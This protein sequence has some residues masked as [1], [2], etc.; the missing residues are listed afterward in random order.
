MSHTLGIGFTTP[1][2]SRGTGTMIPPAGGVPAVSLTSYVS[3][4]RAVRVLFV[5]CSLSVVI[6]VTAGGAAAAEF[7]PTSSHV[8][9]TVEQTTVTP[10]ETVGLDASNADASFVEFD[11]DG[12]DTYDRTDETDFVIKT[13]YSATGTY[14]PRVHADGDPDLVASCGTVTVQQNTPP[15]ANL[16]ITPNPA[17]TGETVIFDATGSTDTDGSIVEYRFRFNDRSDTLVSD[18]PTVDYS[19]DQSGG[20]ASAVTVVDT[21]GATDT[22]GQDLVV[23][24][25]LSAVCRADPTTVAPGETVTLDAS[26]SNAS[27]VE[28]DT[29]GNGSYDRTGETD[30][31]VNTSYDQPGVYQ[32]RVRA[33]GDPDV[34]TSCGDI[35]V[36]ANEPPVPKFSVDP[37]PG[38][39]GEPVTFNA[40][41]SSDPD[42]T[43]VEYRW[44]FEGDGSPDE[45][46][47]NPV[48]DHTYSQASG[49]A[50]TLTV[51]DDDG[52]TATATGDL[53]VGALEVNEF[54][55][56]RA[57]FVRTLLFKRDTALSSVSRACG[58]SSRA[59]TSALRA[60]LR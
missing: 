15:S 60:S 39:V 13:N 25:A 23:E 10:G 1:V 4:N 31:I 17:Q 35:I 9:C 43:I 33:D 21:D 18:Q 40:S 46:T 26:D 34:F 48:T 41:A 37:R 59:S 58:G 42:G 22:A 45:N 44:D 16:S 51:V 50:P 24:R 29:N 2:I 47:T 30:F 27:F 53:V 38:T 7:G 55:P 28:F 57:V 5:V 32:P 14:E 3:R 56:D 11:T 6:T 20:Y 49:Y 54:L 52:A 36:K 8:P 12:D 19:Y